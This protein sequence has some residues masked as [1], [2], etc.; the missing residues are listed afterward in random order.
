ML[1]AISVHQSSGHVFSSCVLPAGSMMSRPAAQSGNCL[2]SGLHTIDE[3]RQCV[4]AAFNVWSCRWQY[5]LPEAVW[6]GK[7]VILDVGTGSGK[8][9]AFYIPALFAAPGQTMIVVTALN[10]LAAQNVAQLEAAGI[11]AIAI[12][13]QTATKQNFK[14]Q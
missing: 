8:T 11:S 10:V 12:T 14:V 1:S 7:H 5:Q 3:V 4:Q 6:G 13:G 2:P 9:L